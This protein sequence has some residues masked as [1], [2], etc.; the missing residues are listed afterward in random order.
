MNARRALGV[1]PMLTSTVIGTSAGA[2][3]PQRGFVCRMPCAGQLAAARKSVSPIVGEFRG[4]LAYL[5]PDACRQ[6]AL[7][8]IG[9]AID[10]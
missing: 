6:Q 8:R 1:E 10:T 9:N 3:S 4:T 2:A 7:K 5:L